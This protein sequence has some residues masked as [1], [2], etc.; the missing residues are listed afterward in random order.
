MKIFLYLNTQDLLSVAEVSHQ[1]LSI[2]SPM[3]FWKR[4]GISRMDLLDDLSPYLRRGILSD[5]SKVEIDVSR[6]SCLSSLKKLEKVVELKIYSTEVLSQTEEIVM[7][8]K[9][10]LP[11]VQDFTS[12]H[13]KFKR[14][15]ILVMAYCMPVA[16]YV[17]YFYA[18]PLTTEDFQYIIAKLR[19]LRGIHVDIDISDYCDTETWAKLFNEHCGQILFHIHMIDKIPTHLLRYN[20]E[21][22]NR[23]M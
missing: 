18:S 2:I 6:I 7:H 15:E 23:L 8:L 9:N 11:K 3:E 5:L 10:V 4:F 16:K 17:E 22:Y 13:I 19:N 1:W 14:E 12:K 21:R 20:R